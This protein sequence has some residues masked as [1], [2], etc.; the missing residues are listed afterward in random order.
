MGHRQA[1]KEDKFSDLKKPK[2]L[3]SLGA[4]AVKK[5]FCQLPNPNS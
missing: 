5:S 3:S 1:A 2:H 4:L